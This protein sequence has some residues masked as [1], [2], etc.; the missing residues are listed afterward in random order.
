MLQKTL[1]LGRDLPL[2]GQE[3]APDI[4]EATGLVDEGI[5]VVAL[6]FA[7]EPFA[8]VEDHLILRGCA[9]ALLRLRD[10]GDE[11]GASR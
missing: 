4:H 9:F 1:S 2:A 11:S 10:G 6:M 5:G 3:I 7:G 8:L